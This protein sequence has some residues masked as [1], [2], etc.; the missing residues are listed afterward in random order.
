MVTQST[1]QKS[2]KQKLLSDSLGFV[3]VFPDLQ[4]NWAE[5]VAGLKATDDSLTALFLFF[6]KILTRQ[7]SHL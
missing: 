5:S 2:P 1:A 6:L 7:S 4:K 3:S